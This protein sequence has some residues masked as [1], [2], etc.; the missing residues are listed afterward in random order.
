MEYVLH[1]GVLIAIFSVVVTGFNISSAFTGSISLAHGA[2]FG[3][4]AYVAAA[5]SQRW[6]GE[7]ILTL[8]VAMIVSSVASIPLAYLSLRARGESFIIG[9]LCANGIFATIFLNWQSV[10]GGGQ[11]IG[12]I[13]EGRVFGFR[14]GTDGAWMAT[15]WIVLASVFLVARRIKHSDIGRTLVCIGDDEIFARSL[16]KHVARAKCHSFA[17]GASIASLGGVIYAHYVTYIDPTAFSLDFS[18]MVLTIAVVGGLGEFATGIIACSVMVLL[19]EVLRFT[20]AS[21]AASSNVK[22][23][24]FGV[25]LIAAL[26]SRSYGSFKM[27]N[28][29]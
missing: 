11:G 9:S 8:L 14:I 27:K 6:G 18:V 25:V 13:P 20:G 3:I 21:I 28:T 19:P 15:S 4:G 10:T 26:M 2:F 12:G 17:L 1:L 29:H 16:G 24:V 7:I 5:L 23:I 22:Q